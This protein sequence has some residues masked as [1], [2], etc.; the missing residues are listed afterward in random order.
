MQYGLIAEEVAEVY[1][2]LV[3]FGEDGKPYTVKYQYLATMLL[4]EVQKQQH[5]AEAE[6]EVIKAQQQE[7]DGLKTQLRLQNATMQERL[8]R[9]ESLVERQTQTAVNLGQK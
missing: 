4:N 6:A 1:P 7:I 3:A 2:E 9:L 5:R 8:T